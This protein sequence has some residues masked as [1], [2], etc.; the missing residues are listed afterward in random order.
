[1]NQKKTI[2]AGI[3]AAAVV[4]SSGIIAFAATDS[5]D[6]DSSR[7]LERMP[8]CMATLTDEQRKAVHQT[9][10]DSMSEAIAELVDNGVITQDEADKLSKTKAM[11]KEKIMMKGLNLTDEQKTA[12]KEARYAAMQE[13]RQQENIRREN[14]PPVLLTE[15]QRAA[16]YEAM[17]NIMG[18]KLDDLVAEGTITQDQADELVDGNGPQFMGPG[19]RSGCPGGDRSSF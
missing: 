14:R 8:S 1:M 17:K 13:N 19:G 6:Q 15:D 2:L 9:R 16:L 10:L 4:L 5:T 12:A 7:E 18:S 11:L 3:T